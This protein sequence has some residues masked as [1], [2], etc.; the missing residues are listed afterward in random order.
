MSRTVTCG[1]GLTLVVT[2]LAA[3]ST[4]QSREA[5]QPKDQPRGLY[6]SPDGALVA[7]VLPIGGPGWEWSES[8]IEIRTRGGRLLRYVSFAFPGHQ[9]GEGVERAAWTPDSKFFVFDTNFSGGHQPWHAPAYFY[10]R[11][12]NRFR[13]LDDYVGPGP[14]V[15]FSVAP[16][17]VVRIDVYDPVTGANRGYDTYRS[18]R[19]R[20][21]TLEVSG[22]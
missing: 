11:R 10:A 20:L 9:H 2:C 14:S 17:D 4:A 13:R 12:Q 21:D 18:V 8:R 22:P 1:I 7:R 15:A 6:Q 5:T 3:V 19:I 16:P